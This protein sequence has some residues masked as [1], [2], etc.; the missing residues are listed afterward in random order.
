MSLWLTCLL[1]GATAH[2]EQTL[3]FW[4]RTACVA[5]MLM[6]FGFDFLR[7]SIARGNDG[8]HSLSRRALAWLAP[9]VPLAVLV[10]TP[11]FMSSI[12]LPGSG[13]TV[14]VPVYGPLYPLYSVYFL[15]A[16]GYIAW[17]M[18]TSLRRSCGIQ[19]VEL[20]FVL[21]GTLFSLPVG[22]A[23]VAISKLGGPEIGRFLPLTVLVIDGFIAYG[24][25]S[26]HIMSAPYALHRVVA[27]VTLTVYLGIIYTIWWFASERTL[28]L[29]GAP[30]TTAYASF[31]ATTAVAVSLLAAHGWVHRVARR[32]FLGRPVLSLESALEQSNRLLQF[33]THVDALLPQIVQLVSRSFGTERVVLLL[34][35]EK[36]MRFVQRYPLPEGNE[37]PIVVS[38]DGPVI[39]NLRR[40]HE[41]ILPDLVERH[42]PTSLEIEAAVALEVARQA[43]TTFPRTV[44]I[45]MG[46]R[47]SDPMLEAE[48]LDLFAAEP[49]ELEGP[50]L[51]ATVRRAV[52]YLRV[53]AENHAL[54]GAM[55]APAAP[56]APASPEPAS[57]SVPSPAMPFSDAIRHFDNVEAMFQS[58]VEGVAHFAHVSRVGIFALSNRDTHFRF[59]AGTKCLPGT[60]ERTRS[61][62]DPFVRWLVRHAHAVS[63]HKLPYTTDADER[64]ML[65]D[66]LESLGAEVIIPLH[67]RDR[68]I[69]WLFVGHHV[70]GVPFE[71]ADIENLVSLAESV[72]LILHNALLHE[73]VTLQKTLAETVL[74]AIPVGIVAADA[75]GVIRWFNDAAAHGDAN[76][77]VVDVALPVHARQKER[78]ETRVDS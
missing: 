61:G 14:A 47:R 41:P 30:H 13:E 3:D 70:T 55:P 67:G 20:Q 59:R 11:W 71:Q 52:A 51:Q 18:T 50:R 15:V 16:T 17:T 31:I 74:H 49:L 39:R 72:S 53:V 32:L 6:P 40:R 54:R 24:I 58:V 66:V 25:A 8:G 76:G 35:D 1:L 2:S 44:V 43:A 68:V 57:A 69:G 21:M 63:R 4:V 62:Q 5:G 65:L 22:A 37:P 56:A 78:N 64:V 29:A 34:P 42:N 7:A 75:D 19:R 10:Q 33:V 12:A 46:V 9:M 38:A 48:S 26:R 28:R 60:R 23:F 73:E 36:G 45:A 27:Y 77:T